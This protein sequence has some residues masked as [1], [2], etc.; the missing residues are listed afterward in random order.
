[1]SILCVLLALSPSYAIDIAV[2]GLTGDA[3]SD[4]T[5]G[6]PEGL[7]AGYPS[8]AGWSELAHVGQLR[9]ASRWGLARC[10]ADREGDLAAPRPQIGVLEP[11]WGLSLVVTAPSPKAADLG[12]VKSALSSAATPHARSDNPS[13]SKRRGGSLSR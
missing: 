13:R 1:M 10:A 11:M 5:C 2:D 7:G 3:L 12:V 8:A 6:R 9:N 4:R